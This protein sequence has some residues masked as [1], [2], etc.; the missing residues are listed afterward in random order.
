MLLKWTKTSLPSGLMMNPNPFFESNH[1]TLP[2]GITFS[3]KCS[4]VVPPRVTR[5]ARFEKCTAGTAG[6]TSGP[7]QPRGGGRYSKNSPGCQI[8]FLLLRRLLKERAHGEIPECERGPPMARI[9]SCRRNYLGSQGSVSKCARTGRNGRNLRLVMACNCACD[10][11]FDRRRHDV[12]WPGA[13][14][15]MG[16]VEPNRRGI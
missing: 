6:G 12:G 14:A 9:S 3:H 4:P 7:V 16:V 11:T 5:P 8:F 13:A 1:L 15:Q 10:G 2:V